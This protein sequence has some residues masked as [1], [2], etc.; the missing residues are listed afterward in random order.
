M[1]LEQTTNRAT[2]SAKIWYEVQIKQLDA[3]IKAID[4]EHKSRGKR[5]FILIITCL[6]AFLY[7][8]P[9]QNFDNNPSIEIPAISLKIPLKDAISVFPTLIAAIY[10]VFLSSAMNGFLLVAERICYARELDD[11]KATG[12]IKEI[13]AEEI[14]FSTTRYIILPTPLHHQG[15][16]FGVAAMPKIIVDGFVGLVFTLFP[17][18]IT[19][20]LIIKSWQLLNNSLILFWNIACLAIMILAFVGA[21]LGARSKKRL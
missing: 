6:F 16:T 12:E 3:L 10:L 14:D 21:V 4:S 15:F 8:Y 5:E 13:S 20:Y 7:A 9:V 18:V 11:F 1:E 2:K 17:Y 19:V